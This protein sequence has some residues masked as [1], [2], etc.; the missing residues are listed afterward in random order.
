MELPD[1]LLFEDW[2]PGQPHE[3]RMVSRMQVPG[4][5]GLA[6]QAGSVVFTWNDGGDPVLIVGVG[7]DWSVATLMID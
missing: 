5:Y 4:L 3:R 7:P 6:D 2:R 1:E